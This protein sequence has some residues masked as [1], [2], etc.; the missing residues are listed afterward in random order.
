MELVGQLLATA[1]V[2]A[3]PL[4]ERESDALGET[5]VVIVWLSDMLDD[6]ESERLPV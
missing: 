3:L 5:V 2:L 1:L 4:L 6:A